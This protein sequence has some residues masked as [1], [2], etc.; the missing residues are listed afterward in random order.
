MGAGAKIEEERILKRKMIFWMS[1]STLGS[2]MPRY[3]KKQRNW[4]H[5]LICIWRAAT[6]IEVGFRAHFSLQ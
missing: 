6:S 4:K 1:G 3:W 5:R 2:A